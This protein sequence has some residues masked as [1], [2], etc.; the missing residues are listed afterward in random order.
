V[1]GFNEELVVGV[2]GNIC[3]SAHGHCQVGRVGGE[4]IEGV[5]CTD[6]CEIVSVCTIST[7]A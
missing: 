5:E 6:Q 4:Y 2:P 3:T 7:K 1:Y